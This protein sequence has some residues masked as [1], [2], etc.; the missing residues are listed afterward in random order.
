MPIDQVHDLQKVY[1]SI[2]DSMARPGKVTNLEAYKERMDYEIA[3][4]DT[5]L[6]ITMTLLDGE[7]SFH[8]ISENSQVVKDKIAAYTLAKHAPVEE[9]DFIIVL[10]DAPDASIVEGMRAA[11]TGDLINP[12]HSSTWIMES[13]A[14]LSNQNQLKLTGPG[15]KKQKDLFTSFKPSIW[16]TRSETV[17]EYPLG[18]DLMLTDEKWQITCIPRTT[19]V[20]EQEVR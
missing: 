12:Q 15:I 6:L 1:R 19:N 17:Q 16:Q 9:A 3:C 10:K 20:S 11:K 18:I 7:V 8:V 14:P 4:Y 2:L 5:T 13:S